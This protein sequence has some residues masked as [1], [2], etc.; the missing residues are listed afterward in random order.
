MPYFSI[1][2]NQKMTETAAADLAKKASAFIANLVG[3]PEAYVMTAV[4]PG[5][6]MTFGGSDE[7]VAYVELK[8][9]GLAQEKCNPAAEAISGF[10]QSALSIDPGRVFIDLVA[11]DRARFAWNGKTFA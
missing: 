9:I 7:P 8:S 6:A 1:Q 5:V 2:T 4:K 11:L 3:K 10:I